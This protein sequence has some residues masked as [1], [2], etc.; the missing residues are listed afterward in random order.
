MTATSAYE[1]RVVEILRELGVEEIYAKRKPVIEADELVSVGLDIYGREQKLAPGAAK[2]WQ[3]MRS[4]AE[5]LGITLQL[6]SAFRNVDY[7]HQ[8]IKR[9]LAAGQKMEEI[10]RVSALPGYSEHH[11]GKAIDLTTPGCETLTGEFEKTKAFGWL[12][13]NAAQFRFTMSYP[14]GNKV[15]VIYEPWHWAFQGAD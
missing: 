10:L 2:A 4:A 6:V 13:E 8:I 1:Q 11:T 12:G 15:G 9:K 7:Q 3:E 5:S 14:R